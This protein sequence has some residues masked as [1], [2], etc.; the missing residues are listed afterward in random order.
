M[1]LRRKVQRR[2]IQRDGM[3]INGCQKVRLLKG[4]IGEVIEIVYNLM[5]CYILQIC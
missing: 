1:V 3:W 4:F 5:C 2:Q